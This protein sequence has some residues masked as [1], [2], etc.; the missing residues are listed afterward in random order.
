MEPTRYEN[1]DLETDLRRYVSAGLERSEILDFMKRD[2]GFYSWS[3]RTLARTL[4]SY[5]IKYTDHQIGVDTIRAAVAQEIQGTGEH[6]GYRAIYKNIRQKQGLNVQ[7]Q[8]PEVFCEIA[9]FFFQPT[10]NAEKTPLIFQQPIIP[11]NTSYF[12]MNTKNPI[13]NKFFSHF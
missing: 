7:G 5:T 13:M 8:P 1:S 4:Q 12:P 3:I 2:Y 11:K 6:L 9:V 10:T